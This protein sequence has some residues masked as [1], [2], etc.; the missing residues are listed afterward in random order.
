MAT[1]RAFSSRYYVLLLETDRQ[2][3]S[4]CAGLQVCSHIRPISTPCL[5]QW[6]TEEGVRGVRT[7]PL[8]YDLRNKR[9]TKRQNMVFP[10]KNT[11]NSSPDPSPSGEG[12]YPLPIPIPP[13]PLP[14]WL[15]HLDLS[16]SKILGTPLHMRMRDCGLRLRL[17][18]KDIS[19]LP[20][21]IRDQ[22][23][24][25]RTTSFATGSRISSCEVVRNWVKFCCFWPPSGSSAANSGHGANCSEKDLRR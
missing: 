21:V 23:A 4:H 14:R 10:T 3:L 17:S 6:R 5:L 2:N 9:V 13:L 1:D 11:K 18:F 24:R 7:L 12:V 15:R 8:A 20:G 25:Y 16:H 22:V 19:F